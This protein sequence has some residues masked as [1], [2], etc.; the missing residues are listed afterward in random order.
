MWLFPSHQLT[1]VLSPQKLCE[2]PG[3]SNSS[4]TPGILLLHPI[5]INFLGSLLSKIMYYFNSH[6]YVYYLPVLS[7]VITD[8]PDRCLVNIYSV[9]T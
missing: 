1:Q 7:S 3:L 5:F 2:P 4:F 8:I 6:F 9:N